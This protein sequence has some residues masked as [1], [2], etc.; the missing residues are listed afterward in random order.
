[1]Y[2]LLLLPLVFLSL[3]ANAETLWSNFSVTYLNGS[4]Y[5]VGDNK[6]QVVTFEHAAGL[7]WGDSFLF[8][9]RLES[10][11]GTNATYAEWSPRFKISDYQNSFL[12]NIYVA[13]TVEIGDGFTHYLTGIGT[14]LKLPHFKFFKLNLY[15]RNNHSGD[16]AQ[17][18]TAAWAIPLGPLTYDGFMDFVPSNDNKATSMNLTSQLKYDLAP[19]IKL[20]SPLF[21][22]IEYVYW[23]NKFGI[24]GVDENNVNFLIKYHF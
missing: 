11:N 24:D 6:R 7:S 9:D 3:D 10:K 15:H 12:R 5:E 18:I 14:D 17:Q 4:N 1:M 19:H 13:T 23:Q 20:S 22:G 16:N 8:V 2:K 21:L